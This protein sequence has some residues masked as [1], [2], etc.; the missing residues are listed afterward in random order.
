MLLGGITI[1]FFYDIIFLAIT[2]GYWW[3]FELFMHDT[4]KGIRRFSLIMYYILVFVKFFQIF[5]MWKVSTDY[6]EVVR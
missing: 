3:D 1:S 6:D 4:E 5:V 2:S